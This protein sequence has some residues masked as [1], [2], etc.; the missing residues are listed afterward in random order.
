MSAVSRSF[1]ESL[2]TCVCELAHR[3]GLALAPWLATAMADPVAAARER[4]APVATG[5]TWEPGADTPTA[6]RG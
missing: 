2:D 4:K 3:D 1:P 5:H 6:V